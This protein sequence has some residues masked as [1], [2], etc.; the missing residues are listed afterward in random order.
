MN[1]NSTTATIES[2]RAHLSSRLDFKNEAWIAALDPRK[3]EE[4]EFHDGARTVDGKGVAHASLGDT[5]ANRRWYSITKRSDAYLS[6]WLATIA[7]RKVFLDYACGNGGQ[8]RK[9]ARFGS[10][11]A[12]GI[13][14]SGES[15]LNARKIADEEQLGDRCIFIQSDC[16]NTE[17]P[18]ASVDAI[19]CCGMLHHLDFSKALPE[20]RRILRPGGR[21]L[22]VEALGHN[23]FIQAYRQFTPDLR[24]G[25]E[26]DHIL[27]TKDIEFAGKYFAIEN[28]RY[29]HFSAIP[30]ALIRNTPFFK[31]VFA[32]LDGFD[33]FVLERLPLLK[34]WSWQVTFEMVKK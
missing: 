2:L 27:R 26:K 15:I 34:K 18:E 5:R 30:T 14:I 22:A 24:T 13:D 7:G 9:A 4:L 1:T 23:P 12:V 28:V 17:L 33:R 8:T 6:N 11:L 32:I 31:P 3:R 29:W 25:F 21:I 20:M 10:A 19:L 16:E